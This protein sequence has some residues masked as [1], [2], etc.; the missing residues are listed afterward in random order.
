MGYR[1]I[2]E[3]FGKVYFKGLFRREIIIKEGWN[4]SNRMYLKLEISGNWEKRGK[5]GREREWE[6]YN[7]KLINMGFLY[8]FLKYSIVY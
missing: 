3:N 2:F 5:K 1:F 4:Y 8:Y 6:V 7:I